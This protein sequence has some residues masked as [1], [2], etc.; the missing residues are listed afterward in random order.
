LP[1]FLEYI[2]SEAETGDFRGSKAAFLQRIAAGLFATGG[3]DFSDAN[4]E[5]YAV[6]YVM[7]DPTSGVWN[8]VSERIGG[9]KKTQHS[10]NRKNKRTS[11]KKN[12]K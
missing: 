7:D 1:K 10:K 11:M 8:V 9:R 12:K 6:A 2:C 4:S 5:S 3:S